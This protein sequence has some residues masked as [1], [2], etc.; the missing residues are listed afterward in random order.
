M[1]VSK[2]MY[3]V[4]GATKKQNTKGWVPVVKHTIF[5]VQRAKKKTESII[6]Y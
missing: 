2:F 3:K 5:M 1:F 6:Y 4:I